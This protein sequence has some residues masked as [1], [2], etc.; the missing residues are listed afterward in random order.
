LNPKINYEALATTGHQK[1]YLEKMEIGRQGW[2]GDK[3][4]FAEGIF[5]LLILLRHRQSEIE[6]GRE[7]SDSGF[8]EGEGEILGW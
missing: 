7:S 8:K 3:F 6:R 1:A 2:E 4:I 5:W